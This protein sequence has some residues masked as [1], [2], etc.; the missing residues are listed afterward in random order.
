MEERLHI[1][2]RVYFFQQA[3]LILKKMFKN[4]CLEG[5][6]LMLVRSVILR[7]FNIINSSTKPIKVT[8]SC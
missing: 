7:T 3:A 4:C 5:I 8:D 2:S 6:T 1:A